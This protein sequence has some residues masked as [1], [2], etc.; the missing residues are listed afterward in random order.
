VG[1]DTLWKRRLGLS[2]LLGLAAAL[3][4]WWYWSMPHQPYPSDFSIAW[5][6]GRALLNGEDPYDVVGPGRAYPFPYR[7]LYPMPALMVAL[8]FAGLPLSVVDPLFVGISA[9]LFAWAVTRHR[10]DAPAL[11]AFASIAM[12]TAMQVSQWA[13]L[14]IAAA[15]MPVPLGFLLAAKPTIGAA[16]WIA[17]PSVRSAGLA[18]GFVA[19]SFV[20]YPWWLEPWRATLDD[21]VHMAAPI[22]T[23]GGPVLLA[24]LWR[25]RLPEARLLLA[26]A[27]VPQTPQIYEAVP[28]FLIAKTLE[29][30]LALVGLTLLVWILRNAVSVDYAAG[31]WWTGQLMVL[32]LYLPCLVMILRREHSTRETDG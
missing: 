14:L 5:A 17:Y 22:A 27:C 2:V 32:L 20:L 30:G 24:A 23:H 29:E 8:P 16:L 4:S 15:L 9:A 10:L 1:T 12:I 3:V 11:L 13:P 25:W 31:L 7:L 26:L 28:L 18:A 19:L 21:T 6:G